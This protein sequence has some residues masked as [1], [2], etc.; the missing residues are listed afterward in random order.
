MIV[1]TANVRAS[2]IALPE[3]WDRRRIH[4]RWRVDDM[5]LDVNRVVVLVVV[6]DT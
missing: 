4:D 5:V 6:L 1:R 3:P 2:I